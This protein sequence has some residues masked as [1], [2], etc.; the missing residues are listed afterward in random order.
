[1]RIIKSSGNGGRAFAY[2]LRCTLQE[3]VCHNVSA[4]EKVSSTGKKLVEIERLRG[5]AVLA[6]VFCHFAFI[7][8]ASP[9]ITHDPWSGVHLF[10]VISGFVVTTSLLRSLPETGEESTFF[11]AFERARG[12]LR[13]F[14]L[15]RLFRI[16]P[17]ALTVAFAHRIMCDVFP[18]QFGST[19]Q[20]LEE[21][22]AFL[23][24]VYN[25]AIAA[26]GHNEIG[27]YWTLSVEEHFYLFLPLLF[28]AVRTRG[29]RLAACITV[30]LLVTLVIRP[31]GHPEGHVDDLGA[32][33]SACSQFRFDALMAGAALAL[34]FP[35]EIAPPTLPPRFVRLGF[36]PVAIGVLWCL[37][38]AVP[39][40]MMQR[41]G[42]I[43][44]WMISALLVGYAALNRGYVLDMPVIR[45]ILEYV[46]SRSYALY[47]LNYDI[48]RLDEALLPKL[49]AYSRVV[50]HGYAGAWLHFAIL[51]A[52][53]LAASE[54]LYR[55][56]E[57]PFIAAGQ[58][59]IQ[60]GPSALPRWPRVAV[61]GLGLALVIFPL[62]HPL[63]RLL[64]PNNLAY[65]HAVAMS[66]QSGGANTPDA[67]VNGQ[68]EED[69][70]AMTQHED[71]PW[72]EIDLGKVTKIQTFVIYNRPDS[73]FDDALP[74][75]LSVSRDHSHY[76][77]LYTREGIF[78]QGLPW[79]HT[80]R[81]GGV[82]ARYVRFS[83]HRKTTLCLSEVELYG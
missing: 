43:A 36:V 50:S 12:P 82:E 45:T 79:I 83:V 5:V 30:I 40:Y 64:A 44:L 73:A 32:Y 2:D 14:Y 68:V 55:V 62:R 48:R 22:V 39:G 37:P 24:G 76:D 15:R 35:K 25:Y 34:L 71:D 29:K 42:A 9:K 53:A 41:P 74:L 16:L 13:N 11:D 75:A 72:I 49:G 51:L 31:M 6:T 56:I 52:A 77:T 59:V 46:G 58:A 18:K 26:T 67:L 7:E 60:H 27:V 4:G 19:G 57:R 66:S 17:A 20:W 28:V 80:A 1:M 61:I 70:C 54:L 78:S 47:L 38:S 10:F 33:E 8:G 21:I 65:E 81:G 69:R 3:T 63:V 23:G